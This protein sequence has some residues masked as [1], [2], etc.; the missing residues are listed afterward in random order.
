MLMITPCFCVS[1]QLK[2]P[3]TALQIHYSIQESLL[4]LILTPHLLFLLYI[5]VS[6]IDVISNYF[7]RD[8][9]V[10]IRPSSF[11]VLLYDKS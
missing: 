2:Y 8:K 11:E 7:Y 4:L 9:D 1:Q 6:A 5:Y 10:L 3:S